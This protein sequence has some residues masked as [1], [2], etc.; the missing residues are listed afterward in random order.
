MNPL[1]MVHKK[2]FTRALHV[3]ATG[4]HRCHLGGASWQM[5]PSSLGRV[6]LLQQGSRENPVAASFSHHL[7]YGACL[8]AERTLAKF[9]F[10]TTAAGQLLSRFSPLG[11]SVFS[12]A[13]W[14]E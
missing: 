4:A 9:Y 2:S 1:S 14:T 12:F 8:K 11:V 5:F 13:K 7:D 10:E 3:S 6:Q